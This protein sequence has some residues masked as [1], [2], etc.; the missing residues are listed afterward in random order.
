MVNVR[1]I[2]PAAPHTTALPW[3]TPVTRL[4]LP[5]QTTLAGALGLVLSEAFNAADGGTLLT[6]ILSTAA[7]TALLM[8]PLSLA[9]LAAENTLGLRGRWYRNMGR[10]LLPAL[11]LGALSGALAQFLYALGLTYSTVPHRLIR[12]LG[13]V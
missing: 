8:L 13:G 11:L 12:S 9:L 1:V 6:T 3:T 7:W 4:S 10:I 2:S 5:L